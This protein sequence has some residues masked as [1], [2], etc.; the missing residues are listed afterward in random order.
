[1]LAKPAPISASPLTLVAKVPAGTAE[2]LRILKT[3]VIELL[4]TDLR[5]GADSGMDL[6]DAA[7]AL[8]MMHVI[9]NE[10]LVDKDFVA[11]RTIG[12][13]ELE[14]NVAGYSPELMAP[15]CGVDADTIRMLEQHLETCPTCPP[16]LAALVGVRDHLNRLRDPD[17][18]VDAELAERLR[19]RLVR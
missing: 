5:L 4:L 3:E 18:V 19:S 1:M 14:K 8:A 9:V 15:I 7:L 11:S 12:Y 6:L 2:A 16:L 17:S 10:G 13:E